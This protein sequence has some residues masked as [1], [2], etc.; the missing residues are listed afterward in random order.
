MASGQSG[1]LLAC[2][3][4][5]N[6]RVDAMEEWINA[7]REGLCSEGGLLR[8]ERRPETQRARRVAAHSPGEKAEATESMCPSEVRSEKVRAVLYR[9]LRVCQRRNSVPWPVPIEISGSPAIGRPR[10]AL[11]GRD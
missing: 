8:L 11:S 4:E 9:L 1:P 7:V 2:H 3:T 5:M 6:H 10:R